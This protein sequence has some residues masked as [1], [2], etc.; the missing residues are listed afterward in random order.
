[1]ARAMTVDEKEQMRL[2][3][4]A[5]ANYQRNLKFRDHRQRT[6]GIDKDALDAQVA[7]KRRL[8]EEEK[9]NSLMEKQRALEIDYLMETA[10]QEEM[11]MRK[12]YMEDV[13]R[14][15]E[16][17][18]LHREE[19]DRR[20]SEA[21]LNFSKSVLSK[22]GGEDV[23]RK[24]R[25]KAQKEQLRRWTQEELDEKAYR[26]Q[27][28][29]DRE[30][31]YADMIRVIED[32]R[33]ATE[34]EEEQMRKEYVHTISQSNKEI[35][36]YHAEKMARWRAEQAVPLKALPITDEIIE[37]PMDSTGRIIRKDMF[38]GFTQA[39]KNKILLDNENM[40]AYKR[41]MAEQERQDEENWHQEQLYQQRVMA[42]AE[43]EEKLLRQTLREEQARV[44]AQQV[45]EAEERRAKEK[46][47]RY[48]GI[49]NEFFSKF[50]TSCR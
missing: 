31:A 8:A 6:I 45:Q 9:K 5:E 10:A 46:Q 43:A 4:K 20:D 50:G 27:Q 30:R 41:A 23:L 18:R 17:A 49:T 33:A 29:Q 1:M 24:E 44:L 47:D 16:N 28:E 37:L 48:G 3:M 21:D 2:K 15:W 36:A 42:Q 7:E 39:Q 40:K 11:Q 38:K 32:I 25:A 12:K 35:A 19:C 26:R 22:F 34:E 14:D 13:K